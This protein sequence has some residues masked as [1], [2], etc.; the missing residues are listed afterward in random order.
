[1]QSASPHRGRLGL[2]TGVIGAL[3]AG[4]LVC[5]A[6]QIW[7]GG[8]GYTPPRFPTPTSFTGSFNFCR[9]MFNSNRREKSGWGTDYPGADLNFSTRL[10][11]LTKTDV[12]MGRGNGEDE[13]PDAVVVRPTDDAL[14]QC[15]FILMEDAGTVRFNDV[16]AAR[17]R[18]Y[19]L[20][21]GF[22]LVSDYHGTY[23]KA[24]FDEEIARVLP[25][26]KYPVVDLTPP[27][28]PIWN[29]M[30]H[31]QQLPQMAS[32]QT[33][34]RTG[35]GTIER[36]NDDRSGP[37]ARGITDARGRLMVVMIHNTDI[38]DGWEREGED[39]A[40]FFHFSPDAYAVGI[41]VVLYALTH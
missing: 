3:L 24:Q 29:T 8:Y 33:W 17:L 41:D 28:H 12:K 34:R 9:L 18:E 16:E 40:Y 30:F 2:V 38:P 7:S 11:E 10:A 36:W 15:P 37:D 25:P 1:M 20:K 5:Y 27:D 31:L 32:I 26:A 4:V 13:A 6:Q 21:G 22:L 35:G 19:L 39:P 23:A 14:F